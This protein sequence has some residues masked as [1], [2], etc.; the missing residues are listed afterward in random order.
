MNWRAWSARIAVVDWTE[1]R[2]DVQ[3]VVTDN[4]GFTN[5]YTATYL[6]AACGPPTITGGVATTTMYTPST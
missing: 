1:D 3:L 4:G 6:A 5:L 2:V